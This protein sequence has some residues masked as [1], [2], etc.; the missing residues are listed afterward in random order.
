MLKICAIEAPHP[1]T[2]FIKDIKDN[3]FVN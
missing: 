1:E 3:G 2:E